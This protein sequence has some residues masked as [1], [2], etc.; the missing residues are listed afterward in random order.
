[1]RWIG[2]YIARKRPDVVVHLGDHWDMPSLSSW[3]SGAKK[4]AKG[5]CKVQDIQAGNKALEILEGELAK[6]NFQPKRKILLE[7]NHDGFASG[8]RIRR[9]LDDNPADEGLIVPSQFADSWLGWERVPFMQSIEVD[10]IRYAHL[11][12]Y[13]K[14][15]NTTSTGTRYGASSAAS[16]LSALMQSCT[17][18]HKQGL[19]WAMQHTPLKTYRSV[20][21]GSCYLHDEDY[22]GPNQ[23]YWRGIL[24]KHDVR[25]DGNPNHYDL[26]EVSLEYLKRKYG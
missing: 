23:N 11:F 13:G 17:A 22:L 7:G 8:G 21:A 15:G 2:K 1:M 3:E 5:L 20:I 12:P 6:A 14:N 9:Y 4:A 19:D 10:N 26:Q 18:G 25:Q 24:V 16:Q